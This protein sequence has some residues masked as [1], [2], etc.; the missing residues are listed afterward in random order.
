M[1]QKITHKKIQMT[2]LLLLKNFPM[3]KRNPL[4]LLAKAILVFA[5]ITIKSTWLVF[6]DGGPPQ[7]DMVIIPWD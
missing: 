4:E 6:E 7:S 2:K 5:T 1:W 3:A